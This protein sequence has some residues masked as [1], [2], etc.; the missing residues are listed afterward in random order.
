[1]ILTE[2][3]ELAR[4]KHSFLGLYKGLKDSQRTCP[5]PDQQKKR[6]KRLIGEAL[7]TVDTEISFF[8]PSPVQPHFN[9]LLLLPNSCCY[10][11]LHTLISSFQTTAPSDFMNGLI[12]VSE[13]LAQMFEIRD[14]ASFSV[15][16]TLLIRTVFDEVY[17][18]I[19]MFQKDRPYPDVLALLRNVTVRDLQPPLEYA[20][21]MAEDDYPG[22]V[23][24]NDNFFREVI[25]QLELIAFYTN[26][27][28]VIHQLHLA[29][30]KLE[31]A[32]H[33]HLREGVEVALM[34]PF[35]VTFG[36]LLCS[37][38]GAVIPDYKRVAEFTIKYAPNGKLCPAFDF[39]LT[40]IRVTLVHL[41]KLA[42]D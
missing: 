2:P 16:V 39:A 13:S 18:Q 8:P 42:N 33:A 21:A 31:K 5:A 1:M 23:F 38:A 4:I 22:L 20:P 25:D 26:P 29:L 11:K 30:K 15:I 14:T 12:Q 27:L 19:E 36:L 17:P 35:D 32:A 7:K 34:L 10:Q 37:L 3:P 40:K 9:R 6:I 24:R 41:E 28:D